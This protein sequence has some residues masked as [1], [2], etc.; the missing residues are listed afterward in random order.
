[1]GGAEGDAVH[2]EG[3]DHGDGDAGLGPQPGG[4]PDRALYPLQ[5][6]QLEGFRSYTVFKAA[7]TATKSL[8]KREDVAATHPRKLETIPLTRGRGFGTRLGA[9]YEETERAQVEAFQQAEEAWQKRKGEGID[10]ANPEPGAAKP[11]APGEGLEL[12][13][14][15]SRRGVSDRAFALAQEAMLSADQLDIVA[16][17]VATWIRRL[18]G[19]RAAQ[20]CLLV[21]GAGGTGK[22]YAQNT[23]LRPLAR[24]LFG[25]A[26]ERAVACAN[27]AARVLGQGATTV[28]AA[29]KSARRQKLTSQALH[30]DGRVEKLVE[31]WD[32]V[33]LLV[34]DEFGIM[35]TD[36]FHALALS[37][38]LGRARSEGLDPDKYK[39]EPFGKIPVCIAQG[40]HMQ[41]GPVRK[42]GVIDHQLGDP[43]NLETEDGWG[44]Y[45]EFTDCVLLRTSKRFRDVE[46]PAFLEAM[47]GE[48]AAKRKIP[49][50]IWR[51]FQDTWVGA[52]KW[53]DADG[54]DVRFQRKEWMDA[55]FVAI[56]WHVVC[57]EQ[58]ERAARD[59]ARAGKILVY[60]TACDRCRHRLER[61]E[62]HRALQWANAT[63]TGKL[64]GLLPLFEGMRLRL[65]QRVSRAQNLVQDAS[66]ILRGV[67]FHEKEDTTW[68]EDSTH[69]AW[70]RGYVVLEYMPR[71]L[72]IA[73]DDHVPNPK[74]KDEAGRLSPFAGTRLAEGLETGVMILTPATMDTEPL[75][76]GNDG[77]KVVLSRTQMGVTV[78]PVRTVQAAQG[79]SVEYLEAD[80]IRPS[81]MVS[82]DDY[83]V[84][85]YVIF[86]RA[87]RMDR[88]LIRNPPDKAFLERG[89]SK[90]VLR[91]LRRLEAMARTTSRKAAE[92]R[93][94]LG[95]PQRG[96]PAEKKMGGIEGGADGSGT[97]SGVG[98]DLGNPCP[99]G[100]GTDL[101][102]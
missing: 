4:P 1:M 63:S 24:E 13:A 29:I 31:E 82:D 73:M 87:R 66:G 12:L 27:S 49:K 79:M 45:K 85:L 2:E 75:R 81:W 23:V 90:K 76:I 42:Q 44:I 61:T 16:L 53:L 39:V 52:K 91:E 10:S 72:F 78:E 17:A 48:T 54:K 71:A 51:A 97:G 92:A 77:R 36:L 21:H 89:P 28:H 98:G 35:A 32:R 3:E 56:E 58:Q 100:V 38:T 83:W 46:L 69:P 95:W 88:M 41:L 9:D 67:E 8:R 19:D 102:T 30:G 26:G 59:A 18:E 33:W 15:W 11:L 62:Y 64:L 57:R 60:V 80:C 25:A 50:E 43:R 7:R 6:N 96:D 20:L 99:T 37:C 94:F 55:Q 65:T 74:R 34:Q 86:S 47:R 101:Y 14:Q 84:H 5:S 93:E 68:L 70:E 40:D 22:T